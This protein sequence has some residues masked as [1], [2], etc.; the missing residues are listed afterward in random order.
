LFTNNES[1]VVN[2]NL[3]SKD[4]NGFR[5]FNRYDSD[6]NPDVDYDVLLSNVDEFIEKANK[7]KNM[8]PGVKKILESQNLQYE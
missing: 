8:K 6:F 3:V 5:D 1:L 4:G 2:K 7:V